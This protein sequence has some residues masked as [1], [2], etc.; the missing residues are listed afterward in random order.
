[1]V[2]RKGLGQANTFRTN[3]NTS[4]GYGVAYADEVSGHR[5]VGSLADLYV[6]H[7][8]QLS[9]SG[10]NT[11]SDAVGQLWYVV[12]ADGNGN[13]CYYQLKDW[14]KRND[15]AGWSIADYT[16]K[17][18]LGGAVENIN[19]ELD[20]KEDTA[21]VDQKLSLKADLEQFNNTVSG[22]NA[23]IATKAN[24]LDVTN[25]IGELQDK[26]GD[27]VVVSGNV[28]NN[29]DEE[30]ITTEGDTPQT[31]VLKLKDRAYDS[32]NASGKGYKILRKNWQPIN[33][34]RKNVLTQ[35]MINEPN[36]IY[37]IRYDFDLNGAEIQIK[38]GCVLLFLGGCVKNGAIIF[39]NTQIL[40]NY[41]FKDITDA[42][43]ECICED[44]VA[45]NFSFVSDIKGLIFILSQS[46]VKNIFLK[47]EY[48]YQI[49]TTDYS[50][51]LIM[52]ENVTGQSIY[53]NNC[54]IIDSRSKDTL[55]NG[56]TLM[57]FDLLRFIKCSSITIS[58]LSFICLDKTI[59]YLVG[60][61]KETF[62]QSFMQFN[63]SKNITLSNISGQNLCN[64]IAL[65]KVENA[66]VS[67]KMTNVGYNIMLNYVN[68][69]T[70]VLDTY[71]HA[72]RI[73]YSGA[74]SNS[75]FKVRVLGDSY[76]ATASGVV[77]QDMVSK[78]EQIISHN[79]DN[80]YDFKFIADF[81][82]I[83]FIRQMVYFNPQE[84]WETSREQ[85]YVV[86]G[87]KII[88]ELY[89]QTHPLY[90]YDSTMVERREDTYPLY[91]KGEIT[92]LC[93]D[94]KDTTEYIYPMYISAGNEAKFN[95]TYYNFDVN[96]IVDGEPQKKKIR[97]TN[98]VAPSVVTINSN[99]QIELE[100]FYLNRNLNQGLVRL[101]APC[102]IVGQLSEDALSPNVDLY[103]DKIISKYGTF[104]GIRRLD[105][106]NGMIKEFTN[107]RDAFLSRCEHPVINVSNKEVRVCAND[108]TGYTAKNESRRIK[109][110]NNT[111]SEI[112]IIINVK[113]LIQAFKINAGEYIYITIQVIDFNVYIDYVNSSI[114]ISGPFS[115]KPTFI[116]NGSQ[117]FNTDTHKMIT[118]Y[119]NKWW[120]PDGTEVVE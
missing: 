114:P 81:D 69:A 113:N 30:D 105:I 61:V 34:E 98:L 31:Q 6:L 44:L 36:T 4:T 46:K 86:D 88:A 58:D 5:T 18:E 74:V 12:D 25:A 96:V 41:N 116:N 104:R 78:D 111:S 75:K 77:L 97:L 118:W 63:Y 68:N 33:G 39:N 47:S 40:G 28:T 53:G 35:A 29:P 84:Q 115:R 71:E 11:G 108:I 60:S 103:G 76:T 24:A 99:T 50:S 70:V 38:D 21:S 10:D 8:W 52:K 59:E 110:I 2:K 65:T 95:N 85:G 20:K 15:A 62:G 19:T 16:T 37:E 3:N 13:G 72:H 94:T 92:L 1:M 109:I 22:I 48:T 9:A 107:F 43:G 73:I 87:I 23:N 42:T 90:V 106:K 51:Y 56:E 119:D 17:A 120:N 45:D 32:L 80:V 79:H 27:R 100:N 83:Y 64:G 14:S 93:H 57:Y 101:N 89:N 82:N 26:I 7:D 54:K 117:Y 55:H 102:N 66:F 112:V 49:D 91:F 67:C